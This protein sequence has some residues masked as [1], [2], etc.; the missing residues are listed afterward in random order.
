MNLVGATTILKTPDRCGHL[1]LLYVVLFVRMP[2]G[3]PAWFR[4]TTTSCPSAISRP[5]V[6]T[7]SCGPPGA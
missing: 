4:L 6:L 5:N 7:F 3:A 1:L 2:P